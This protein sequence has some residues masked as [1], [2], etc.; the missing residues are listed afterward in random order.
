MRAVVCLCVEA[1]VLLC[2]KTG[3]V[4]PFFQLEF[5]QSADKTFLITDEF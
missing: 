2:M 1:R 4:L 3:G 5:L